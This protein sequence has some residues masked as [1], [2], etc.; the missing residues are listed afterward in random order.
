MANTYNIITQQ[1]PMFSV[2][3]LLGILIAWFLWWKGTLHKEIVEPD[4]ENVNKRIDFL[5][6][7]TEK[8]EDLYDR[9]QDNIEHKI[10]KMSEQIVALTEKVAQL[11]GKLEAIKK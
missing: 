11:S 6:T 3:V 8:L 9:I 4:I 7:R 2:V 1:L 10:D 5:E